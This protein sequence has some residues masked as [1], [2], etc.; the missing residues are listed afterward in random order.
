L[1]GASLAAAYAPWMA[2]YSEDAEDTDPRLQ[3]T[4]W[5]IF[6]IL[7]R[8]VAVLVLVAVPRVV[9]AAGW[10]AW[11]SISLVCLLLFVPAVLLFGGGW[12]RTMSASQAP[13]VVYSRSVRAS[14]HSESARDGVRAGT[15]IMR[16]R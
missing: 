8:T 3:G 9:A 15:G 16:D 1:L 14:G 7:S 13:D 11:L 2:S 6:G 4:A 12:R 5:G 10:Q